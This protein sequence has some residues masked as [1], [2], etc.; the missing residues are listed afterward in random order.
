VGVGTKVTI[1]PPFFDCARWSRKLS[2]L[3]A[4]APDHAEQ[5]LKTIVAAGYL[6]QLVLDRPVAAAAGDRFVLRPTV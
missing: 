4:C 5:L 1:S 2:G 6:I 3:V